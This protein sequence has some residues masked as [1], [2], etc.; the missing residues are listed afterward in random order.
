MEEAITE[1]SSEHYIIETL[2]DND[3]NFV[4]EG[5]TV[6]LCSEDGEQTHYI[7]CGVENGQIVL[8]RVDEDVKIKRLDT[9]ETDETEI[10]DD[11]RMTMKY[12]QTIYTNPEEP[13]KKL[14]YETEFKPCSLPPNRGGMKGL[15][16]YGRKHLIIDQQIM[17]SPREFKS[18]LNNTEDLIMKPELAPCTKQQ[19]RHV[20]TGITRLFAYPAHKMPN[21]KLLQL[22]VS[23]CTSRK[24]P[25]TESYSDMQ[26]LPL[27]YKIEVDTSKIKRITRKRRY[28]EA[29]EYKRL[30]LEQEQAEDVQQLVEAANSASRID[31]GYTNKTEEIYLQ[32]IETDIKSEPIYIME[33]IDENGVQNSIEV[34]LQAAAVETDESPTEIAVSDDGNEDGMQRIIIVQQGTDEMYCVPTEYIIP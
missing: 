5:N 17:I 25:N 3:T 24:Q 10:D 20:L 9:S 6:I 2:Q 7:P 12:D 8:R 13:R 30:K 14:S 16:R 32:E 4:V 19:M 33:G 21:N 1:N 31:H 28:P 26:L 15:I 23:N 29:E 34:L 22:Y 18:Q 11:Q 27:G